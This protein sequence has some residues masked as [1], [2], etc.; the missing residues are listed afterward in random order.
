MRRCM[1]TTCYSFMTGRV[2]QEALHRYYM[3]LI[4]DRSGHIL[5]RRCIDT[6]CHSLMTEVL[7]K[8]RCVNA[9]W[10][11]TRTS[12][13]LELRRFPILTNNNGL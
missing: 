11:P 3:S 13:A 4:H 2:T 12:A 5:K 6:T 8:R 1:D 9:I 7:Y 10:L